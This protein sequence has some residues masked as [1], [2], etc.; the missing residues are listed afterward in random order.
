MKPRLGLDFQY[1]DLIVYFVLVLL[2]ENVIRMK[3]ARQLSAILASKTMSSLL[4]KSLTTGRVGGPQP[5][6]EVE[7]VLLIQLPWV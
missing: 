1:I 4:A 3:K 6:T 5:S 7:L 2:S